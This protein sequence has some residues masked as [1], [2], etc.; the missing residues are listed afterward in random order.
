MLARTLGPVQFGTLTSALAL[1]TL[2]ASLAT[3]GVGGWW[4]RVFGEEGYAAQR[5]I[6]PSLQFSVIG[7][8][9]VITILVSWAGFGPHDSRT[10]VIIAL[11]ST[12][13][14]GSVSID[15]VSAKFQL[16][17]NH[18]SL[19]VWQLTSHPLRLLGLLLLA[20]NI[21][22]LTALHVACLYLVI[23]IFISSVGFF[24]LASVYKGKLQL[25]G[26]RKST[27]CTE[28]ERY[29][30]N[31][32]LKSVFLGVT[33]FGLE[34]FLFLVYSQTDLVLLRYLADEEAVG[35]Y[36]GAAVFMAAIYLPPSVLYQK[37]LLPKIHRWAYEEVGQ[38]NR[39]IWTGGALMFSLGALLTAI[40][41]LGAPY[42]VPAIL[43]EVYLPAVSLLMLLAL[44][45][46]FRYLAVHLGIIL[47]TRDLIWVN[48]KLTGLTA[49]INVL[50]NII[51]IPE[52]GGLG[53]AIAMVVSYIFLAGLFIIVARRNF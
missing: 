3:F 33:P 28:D 27:V 50:L 32:T 24:H 22:N 44:A 17:E 25:A 2:V 20:A 7:L 23:A 16:E 34:G 49:I 38:L 42:F 13:V 31:P 8:L 37:F 48:L 14:I 40:I 47:F 10:G 45:A 9:A 6:K 21:A 1:V 52:Y 39:F 43:G 35:F 29:A 4:L 15:L 51:L 53:S 11:L 30:E 46:P 5:W 19:A 26:H 12:V 36:S 41:W 18:R